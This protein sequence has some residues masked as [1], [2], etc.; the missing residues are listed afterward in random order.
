MSVT[1][2][3]AMLHGHVSYPLYKQC[4]AKYLYTLLDGRLY[5]CPFIANA[6]KL[7]GIQDNP[8]NY[9]DLYSEPEIVKR[10]IKRLVGGVKFLP[11]CD[12][13]DGRPYDATSAK[14]YNGKGLITAGIQTSKTLPYKIY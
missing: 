4:C 1:V 7:K 11:A 10:K 2:D 13:C 9:V 5:S 3:A 12:F 14:G 8:S 6:A